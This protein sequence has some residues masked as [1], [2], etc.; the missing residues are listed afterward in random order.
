MLE[1]VLLLVLILALGGSPWWGYSR[2]W[3]WG[4]GGV[5]WA[6]VVVLLLVAVSQRL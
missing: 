3:G 4:P 2:N 5:L 1:I 6:V